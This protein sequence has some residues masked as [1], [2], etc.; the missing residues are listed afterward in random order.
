MLK[1]TSWEPC[2]EIIGGDD[3]KPINTAGNVFRHKT[4]LKVSIRLPPLIDADQAYEKI[5]TIIETNPPYNC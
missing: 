2:L 5:K 4:E 1:A 3:F